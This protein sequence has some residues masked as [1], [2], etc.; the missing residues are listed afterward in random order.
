V[1]SNLLSN[2]V[3]YSPDGGDVTVRVARVGEGSAGE[4]R[5]SVHDRGLGIPAADLPH[6]FDRFY[7]GANVVGQIAGSGIGLAG[8]AAIVAQHG[9]R[10]QAESVEG[11]GSTFTICLPLT[12][13][14]TTGPA[15]S[16]APSGER[17]QHHVTPVA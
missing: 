4:A 15:T 2:A 5:V 6:V 9:G 12:A 8:A 17:T 3:K 11:Q 1:L 16:D 10:L 13:A 7:R 14:P